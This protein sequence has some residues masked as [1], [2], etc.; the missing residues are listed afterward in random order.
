MPKSRRRKIHKHLKPQNTPGPK[1]KAYSPPS[2]E[3][4]RFL[5]VVSRLVAVT[6]IFSIAVLVGR[7]I[8]LPSH[9]LR[10]M[11]KWLIA[12][13]VTLQLAVTWEMVQSTRGILAARMIA[14]PS[15]ELVQSTRK[16]TVKSLRLSMLMLVVVLVPSLYLW[17][18]ISYFGLWI[19]KVIPTRQKVSENTF[20]VLIFV[21]GSIMSG[22]LGNA[23]YDLLKFIVRKSLRP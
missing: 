18:A 11:P 5:K 22:L 6:V 17:G 7:I 21:G 4:L 1:S 10:D 14:N 3:D 9:P 13:F 2:K 16:L 19:Q 15:P 23:A 20:L 8:Y 12:S